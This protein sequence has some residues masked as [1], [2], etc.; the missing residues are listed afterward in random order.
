MTGQPLEIR[1]SA[2]VP[3]PRDTRALAAQGTALST[4]SRARL[5][6]PMELR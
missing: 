3:A 6:E 1:Y 4:P 5:V 2:T